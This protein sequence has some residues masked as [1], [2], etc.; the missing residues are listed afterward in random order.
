MMR[1]WMRETHGAQFELVRHF[2]RRLFDSEMIT[3]PEQTR[4]ALI[5]LIALLLPWFQVLYGPLKLKY[6]H[7]AGLPSPA[8]YRDA[9]RADELWLI[10]LMMSTIGLLTAVKWQSLFPDLR[11]YRVL[12]SLPLRPRQI[13]AA[14]LLSLLLVAA[15]ALAAVDCFPSAAFPALSDSRWA[16]S[17]VGPRMRAYAAAST[18][19]GA[20]FFFAL[21]ALQGVLLNLLRPRAFRRVTS[22]LQGA[23]VG[24]MLAL[25]VLSFSIDPRITNVVIQPQWSTWLPPVWFLG[26]CQSSSGDPD[27][28]MRALAHRG[29][30]GL[31]IAVALALVAYAIC[32]RRHRTLLLEGSNAP[33]KR[34]RSGVLLGWLLPDARQQGVISFMLHTLGRSAHHRMI[35]MG[36][37]GLAFAILLSGLAGM[38]AFVGPERVTAADFVYFHVVALIFVLIG[39]RHLFSLPTELKANWIFQLTERDARGDWLY[40]V[41]RF[42]FF[43]SAALLWV[44]PLPFELR[45]LGWRGLAEAA[46]TIL[47]G[48]LAYDWFFS[49]WNKL[50]FT[51]SYLPGKTPGWLLALQFFIV[52]GLTPLLQA[53]LL[54][55]LFRPLVYE[56]LVVVVVPAWIRIHA[57]RRSGWPELRLKFDDVPEPPVETLNLR[58]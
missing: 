53:L 55:A 43:W 13:F 18:A 58:G 46:L 12:G 17:G 34:R 30:M 27:P 50:P 29:S 31:L 36:Y 24:T 1:V 5:G 54:A 14:K 51:C 57:L 21:I 15:A 47:I 3:S 11:D 32:Y 8:P 48:L 49:S 10:T 28:L 52:M 38:S 4:S 7:L 20:F 16:F 39:A 35:L 45:F 26:L 42:V 44:V 19:A 56:V 9:L 33:A 6:A 2:L 41:D 23:L 40:A 22:C 37:L 25:I